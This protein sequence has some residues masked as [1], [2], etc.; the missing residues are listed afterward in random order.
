MSKNRHTERL[1]WV[2]K[3]IMEVNSSKYECILDN[4]SDEGAL[5][6]FKDTDAEVP[7]LKPGAVCRLKVVLLNVI[8][9]PCKIVRVNY[10]QAGLV[11]LIK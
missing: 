6:R 3:G 10:P 7:V 1:P 4:I 8:E 2:S 9:Y 11:F 5:I